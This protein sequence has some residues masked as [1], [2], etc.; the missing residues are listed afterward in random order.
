METSTI[1]PQP[2]LVAG[3]AAE[4][5]EKCTFRSCKVVG[6][7][8]VVC[9]A[10]GCEKKVHMMCYQ[11]LILQK[12]ENLAALPPGKVACTK[13][14]HTKALKEASGGGDGAD[15]GG[16]RGNWDCDGLNGP[17][18]PKTSVKI[19][20]DWWMTE[21]N[22]NRF[23]GKNNQG[24]KKIQFCN[25]LAEVMSRETK[26]KRDGKNVL[27]KIQ[28]IEK[29]FKEAHTFA[30]SE[31]GAGIRDQDEGTFKDAVKKKCPYYYDLLEVMSDRASSKPKAT[32][33]EDDALDS[34]LDRE[35]GEEEEPGEESGGATGDIISGLSDMSDDEEDVAEKSV[36]DKSVGTK[37]TAGTALTAATT[38]SKKTRR[39]NKKK[40]SPIMD[41][42]A[43]AALTQA[44]KASEAKMHELVRHHQFLEN[45]EERK[46]KLHEKKEER[47]SNSDKWKGKTGELEYKM[48]LLERY[49][50][51][52]E[53]YH[54]DDAQII[55]F[56]PDM[57]QIVEA[58]SG[59]EN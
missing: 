7:E 42:D 10:S 49:K 46:I 38:S 24:L 39:S 4:V 15:G 58:K 6:A 35:P 12:F 18:D 3:G 34:D 29:T 53:T 37:R 8:L 59:G 31:T 17:D 26:T 43:I 33:Y 55:A 48:K 41:D 1:A 23:C 14:C 52:K 57:K 56:C 30:T 5:I 19:L 21:G 25:Q 28:H 54:W 20:L 51:L 27:N 2:P 16:R 11:G 36:A 50:E 13:K 44:S 47:E 9:A 45:L 32:S 40:S 22:Y